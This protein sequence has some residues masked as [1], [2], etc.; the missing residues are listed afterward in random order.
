MDTKQVS[1]ANENKE[2]QWA[3]KKTGKSPHFWG[4]AMGWYLMAIV[5]VLDFMPENYSKRDSKSKRL[6]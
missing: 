1:P 2:Q 5:D 4:R 3:D 6:D